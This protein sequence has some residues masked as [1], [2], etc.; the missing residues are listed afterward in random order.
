MIIVFVN[1]YN[2]SWLKSWDAIWDTNPPLIINTFDQMFFAHTNGTMD[3]FMN[4]STS[5]KVFKFKEKSSIGQGYF[6]KFVRVCST[7]ITYVCNNISI[8]FSEIIINHLSSRQLNGKLL[9]IFF[10]VTTSVGAV[11]TQETILQI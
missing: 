2:V 1:N 6:I 5:S 9:C 11:C 8:F 4:V 3:I 7:R 10:F